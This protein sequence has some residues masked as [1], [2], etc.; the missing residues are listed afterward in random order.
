MGI[1]LTRV[2]GPGYLFVVRDSNQNMLLYL[3]FSG[4]I[5]TYKKDTGYKLGHIDVFSHCRYFPCGGQGFHNALAQQTI[6]IPG[7]YSV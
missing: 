1:K 5:Q 4:R 7:H 3:W 6:A 2:S